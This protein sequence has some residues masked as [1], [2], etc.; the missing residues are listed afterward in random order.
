MP[1]ET[2]YSGVFKICR[3]GKLVNISFC[4]ANFSVTAQIFTKLLTLEY[5]PKYDYGASFSYAYNG[6]SPKSGMIKVTT[7]KGLYMW[8]TDAN[9]TYAYGSIT[10]MI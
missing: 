10:Y 9:V 3:V 5:T 4:N 7:D 2:Y 8:A 1:V 6:T